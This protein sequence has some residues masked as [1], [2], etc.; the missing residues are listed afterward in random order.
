MRAIDWVSVNL[1][2]FR[3]LKRMTKQELYEK[4][5]V[6]VGYLIGIEKGKCNPSL[7]I[8]EKISEALGIKISDLVSENAKLKDIL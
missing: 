1:Y 8:L 7:E 3:C 2:A 6:S 5:G 4:S